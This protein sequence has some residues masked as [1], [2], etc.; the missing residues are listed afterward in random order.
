LVAA[1]ELEVDRREE[2]FFEHLDNDYRSRYAWLD[3]RVG[4]RRLVVATSASWADVVRD[5]SGVTS[6]E[7]GRFALRDRRDLEVEGLRQRWS[8]QHGP[9]HLLEAG[10]EA[11]RYDA[12]FDYA[13]DLDLDLV[14]VAPFSAPRA[15]AHSF[16]GT[17]RGDHLGVW[18]SERL[19]VGERG[20]AE[21][22]LRWDE[23]DATG[24][25]E[26]S[27][28]ANLAWR[29]GE[30][31]VLRAAWGR[32]VQ[33]QRPYELQVE[34]GESELAPAEVS[35]HRVVGWETLLAPARGGLE[36]VRV[37]LFGRDVANPR[38]RFENLFEHLN[39]FPEI[40]PDRVR[41][42]PERTA[43]EGVELLLRGRGGDAVAWWLAW[44]W[45][46][47]EDRLGGEK[48]R[49][50]LD[51]PHAATLDVDFRLPRRWRLNLAWRYHTGWPTT[52]VEVIRVGQ[53]GEPG[54][55]EDPGDPGE[56]EDPPEE[57]GLVVVAGPLNARRLPDYHRLDLRAS[58]SWERP[59]GRWSLFFDVQNVYDRRNLAGFDLALDEEEGTLELEEENWPGL[60]PSLGV[61]WE[62]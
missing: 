37:E 55:P 17:V 8:L 13:K 23:H 40:E 1:D 43:A 62:F 29:L 21:L 32:F 49:R 60:F 5:R 56:P 36:A 20:T 45:S 6:E 31:T 18:V 3:H 48:V 41:L 9:R 57:P 52:P 19:P 26:L 35:E 44:S 38:P 4:R 7:E 11:R 58:R 46:R 54:E 16:L 10:W 51:Q 61:S 42:A 22:G 12:F 25:E 53:P 33:S 47:V 15:T 28:R 50:S 34:D 59:S 39:Y 14:L 30:R 2:E 24:D 27:P